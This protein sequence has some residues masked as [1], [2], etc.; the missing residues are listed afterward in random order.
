M[1]VTYL[2][3]VVVMGSMEHP[4][5]SLSIEGSL[6]TDGES[7]EDGTTKDYASIT[8]LSRGLGGG[9]GGTLLLFL[10]TLT[11]SNNA[12]LSS[13]GGN[14]GPLG[15]GGGAGG[16]VHFHWSE[17]LTGDLYQPIASVRGKIITGFVLASEFQLLFSTRI[18]FSLHAFFCCI[19][20]SCEC[21]S[22]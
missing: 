8:K 14:G 2:P 12:T 10:S 15:G 22:F 21:Y 19:A 9:S 11:I 7:Y 6:R 13:I 4:L 18:N 5:S 20:L 16:R 17:I 1:F 3:C